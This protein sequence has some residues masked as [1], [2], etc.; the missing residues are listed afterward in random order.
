[1]PAELRLLH[2]DLLEVER[3]STI[4]DEMCAIVESEFAGTGAQAAIAA[5]GNVCRRFREE[6]LGADDLIDLGMKSCDAAHRKPVAAINR[7][8][9]NSSQS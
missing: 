3:R 1:M 7:R 8:Q 2:T 6:L 9:C 5:I 4:S